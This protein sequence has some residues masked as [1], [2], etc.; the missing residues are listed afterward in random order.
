MFK[1]FL[2]LLLT[3]LLSA[4]S[5]ISTPKIL[6]IDEPFVLESNSS[7]FDT[8]LHYTHQDLLNCSPRIEAAYKILSPRQLKVIPRE[9]L[10]SGTNYH[11]S[12]GEEAIQLHT[13]KFQLQ[14]AH[15]YKQTKL[16]RLQFN[17]AVDLKSIKNS[18]KL[19]KIE[20]LTHTDLHY[21]IS[22]HNTTTLLIKIEEPIGNHTIQLTI[23]SDLKT[24]KGVMF[25]QEFSKKFN[26]K[27]KSPIELDDK[28]EPMVIFEKPRMVSLPS[29][30]FAIRIF[31]DDT[32]FWEKDKNIEI[33]GINNVRFDDNKYV[34][35]E[36]RAKFNLSEEIY[37]Y[38]DIISSEFKPN[39]SYQLTLKKGLSHYRELKEDKSY[40]FKTGDRGKSILFEEKKP[41]IS[42]HGEISF[43][44]VNINRATLIVER[45]MDQNLR[46]FMNFS[47]A[48]KRFVGKYTKEILSKEIILNNPKNSISK[49]KFKL[50]DLSQE[51]PFGVYR[52][53]LRYSDEEKEKSQSKILF[54]SNLGISVD[55]AKD[56]A[57]V[58][59]LALDSAKP[60]SSAS[61][62]LYA[63]NNQ[64]LGIARTDEHGVAIIEKADLLS[65]HPKGVIVKY[66]NDQNFLALNQ[67]ISNPDPEMTLFEKERFKAHIYCQSELI[68][69]AGELNAL[70]TIKDRDFISASK[71]P[72]EIELM[73]LYDGSITKKIY[74]TDQYGLIDFHHQFDHEDKTGGYQLIVR[75]GKEILGEKQFKIEAFVPPK[76]ENHITLNQ[77]RYYLGEM[78][79]LNISSN[80]LFGAKASK[81]EGHMTLNSNP[82]AF[83]SKQFK[84]YSFDNLYLEEDDLQYYLNYEEDIQLDEEGKLNIIIPTKSENRVP[85]ILEGM[86]GVTIMDDT[87]PVSN[88][89]KVTLYPYP[90]MVG[91]KLDKDRFEEGESL[92]SKVVLID[93][94]TEKPVAR[95]L[96]AS[97]K[98]SEWHYSYS[99]GNYEWEEE[100]TEIENFTLNANESFKKKIHQNGEYILEIHDL[101]GG[102][103]SAVLFS[104]WGDSYSNLSPKDDLGSVEINFD[105]RLYKK[106]EKLTATIKSPIL[107][108]EL[109]LR[110]ES[111]KVLSYQHHKLHKG[112]AKVE[113]PINQKIPH[114]A[115][116]H[117]VVYR[118]SDSDAKLIPFRA[119]GYK[120]IKPNRNEHKIAIQLDAPSETKSN[121]TIKLNI[122]TDKPAKV[123]ISVVDS[124]ILQLAGQKIA[125]PFE[126]FN[127]QPDKALSYFDLYDQLLAYLTEG[128]LIDFGAGDMPLASQRKHLPPDLGK[129][130]KPFM[131]WSGLIESTTEGSS[132]EL[133]IPEFNGKASVIA[134][135]INDKNIG[136]K[137][138][139]ILIKDKI[140]IKPAY[141]LYL[142]SGDKIDLPIRLFNTTKEPKSIQVTAEIS[143]NLSLDLNESN[144]T[145]APNS[146][147]LIH[148]QLQAKEI[149]KGRIK[150]QAKVGQEQISKGIELP[151]Y[152]PYALSTKTYKGIS[153]KSVEI[154]TPTAYQDAKATITLSDN[155]IGSMR[156]DLKYL[157]SYPYGCA[158]QTSSQIAA[159]HHAKPFLQE[160]RLLG[161]SQ[162]FIRQGIKK[163]RNMQQ[164]TGEF[165]YWA[166]G[167]HVNPY[168]SLYT[169]QILLD[170]H[171]DKVNVGQ[172]IV[173]KSIDMLK[174]IASANDRYLG[175]YSPFHRI[176]AAYIL[177]ENK[178][179]DTST[180][181]MLMEKGF[182]KKHFLSTYYMAAMLKMDGKVAQA[183]KLY[184]SVGYTLGSYQNRAYR[185]QSDNFESNTRDM[186]L[187]FMIKSQ[188]FDKSPQDLAIV[189]KSLDE[190]YSTQEKA[191]ALKAISLYLGKP[192]KHPFNATIMINGKE[193]QYH[194]PSTIEIAQLQGT[195]LKIT[196]QA[197][198]ISYSVELIKH[199]PKVPK[200]KL[201]KQQPLSI[202]RQFVNDKQEPMDLSNLK[203]GEKI[204]SKVTIANM[205]RLNN[206]V[207]SQRI[208]ACLSIVN[209]R[210][211]EG[212]NR[213]KFANVNIDQSYQEIRDDRVIN[214]VNLPAKKVYDKLSKVGHIVQNR[215]VIYTPLIV[216]TQGE[217]QLPAVIT[218][219]MYDTRIQ[220]Y[221][222]EATSIIIRDKTETATESLSTQAKKVVR[223]LYLQEMKNNNP[224]DFLEFF[225]YPIS[226]YY[227]T[228]NANQ[229]TVRQDKENYFKKWGK[230]NYR[231]LQLSTVKLDQTHQEVQVKIVFDYQIENSEKSLTGVSKHLLTLKEIAGKLLITRVE[232]AK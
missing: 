74:H 89:T 51:L 57:F 85:S 152:N 94:I 83:Q 107:E 155:L 144:L 162:N 120:Y 196:P 159:M 211:Q 53:T 164:Y 215:G 195:Q 65:Q 8:A 228:P 157:I 199:L 109:Y 230:R 145:L 13:E 6:P 205:E 102:H 156:A 101:L 166:D 84:A 100:L 28:R 122:K 217:C 186:L 37:Y 105:D 229:E 33:A 221:A 131:I 88:Y 44:S 173:E 73:Q 201:S 126:Y 118:P 204:Y 124:G 87:Q 35:Y 167:K 178:Q 81:L 99:N 10:Q 212:A 208:P 200:N 26:E 14:D 179:L 115:Y 12:Y 130:I 69:P 68:R 30:E 193:K 4:N 231:N 67:S 62:E 59:V 25:E 43:K 18:I 70:I 55:L 98:K 194:Q 206:V 140:M 171:R 207:V 160:D 150:L 49:Q 38:T 116:L 148:A 80:Y 224:Q 222:K 146:A 39:S 218:E 202:M 90:E 219:A 192:K 125:N 141:P 3:S 114:G 117:A 110:I 95:K 86:I 220:D 177:A 165:T 15:F 21:G 93:P 23:K 71:I 9:H 175:V 24:P 112:V 180:L 42:N 170:L 108:G 161:E 127:E 121:H 97:I 29:G 47:S 213:S 79:E 163:L 75:L 50:S 11:C 52:I 31:S 168:A 132:F 78:I 5:I 209:T 133:E 119:I 123:L 184:Q 66:Q 40:N 227:R 91:I 76:I 135:A 60:I 176:Y 174:S 103:S 36:I 182:Y 19:S 16:L 188:Y 158:E 214:F 96:Y 72:V 92:Q 149:G 77:D 17:D 64:L 143:S 197:G 54:L 1:Q 2:P 181:N 61:V 82:I 113:L 128:K 191:I 45:I 20:K 27:S 137:S 151:L 106:G 216:S 134:I 225:H 169:A 203:Q 32:I 183:E 153:N 46:Y 63:E 34:N 22:Q 210:L 136:V 198:A 111:D 56:Q 189:Q 139:E 147:K 129:R 190:L 48:K 187:H 154:T 138:Q 185:N 41:Y 142:L 232:V 7:L 172:E 58:T 104:V 226:L 223:N